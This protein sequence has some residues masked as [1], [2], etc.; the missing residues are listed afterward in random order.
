MPQSD[1]ERKRDERA[2]ARELAIPEP[3]DPD[4]RRQLEQDDAEWLQHY[5]PDVFYNPFTDDHLETIADVDRVLSYGVLKC[6][7]AERGDGKSS[8]VKYLMLK[9]ALQRQLW[10]P[11]V[12]C[13]T[14]PKASKTTRSIRRRLA[15]KAPTTAEI[16]AIGKRGGDTSGLTPNLLADDYPL[17][18]FTARYV[19]PWPS[20]SRNVTAN[21]GRTIHVEWGSAEGYFILP[22]WADECP[23][24]P[25]FMSL[26]WS[27]DE[28]QGCN[29]YDRRP[30][31]V[32]LDDL[33]SRDSLSSE[34]GVIADK[35][36]EQIETTVAG[37]GG[38]GRE[39]GQYFLCTIPSEVA[40]AA[41]YS[42]PEQKPAWDGVRK[43][44]I[45]KWPERMDLW[46]KYVSLYQKGIAEGDTFAREAHQ[47]YVDKREA[48]DAGSEVSNPYR[49]S[50]KELP[51]G[52]PKEISCLQ[53]CFNYIAKHGRES[54]NT[55]HQNDPPK[56]ENQLEVK[57]TPYHV[58]DCAGEMGQKMVDPSTEMICRGVDVRKI[59]LHHVVL[60]TEHALNHRIPDYGLQVHGNS[61]T[62][63]EQAEK[64][65]H[66]A[67]HRLA[68]SWDKD[69]L[70]DSN[71]M[72]RS[73]D[74][75]LID[76][77]WVGS[78]KTEDGVEKS[79]AS[80]PVEKFCMERGLRQWLP[81]K[82]QSPY[83][84]PQPGRGVIIGSNWHI[85]RGKGQKR[86]CDEV[87]W[88]ADH[89]HLLVEEL[90]MLPADNKDRF[91]LF[92]PTTDIYTNHK[93]FADHITVGATEL[94]N[95]LAKNVRSRK[96]RFARDHWWDSVAMAL[97]ARSIEH[98]M[99]EKASRKRTPRP[100]GE[101]GEDAR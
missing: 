99:R 94:K 33:D 2:R 81:A 84:A 43:R 45:K 55:E 98:A 46:D 26:G 7:A 69:P 53:R 88:N 79:W 5:L 96:P 32:M 58:S 92:A 87:I 66:E 71:G 30:D 28:L 56:R 41:K 24:G 25:I 9:K 83:K 36:E 100:L 80:Q 59:E 74:L 44:A 78:W 85:N 21:G 67:L 8:I 62:T 89:W 13:A 61:E 40:A 15:S 42:D 76:K 91:E 68:D 11:L 17:E 38:P 22:T 14:G 3:A 72:V 34:H 97:V 70:F 101:M 29:V 20:R 27:S 10:F 47:F 12:I 23:L 54:F 75:T 95:Q 39:L 48:M 4:R 49:Y 77:G 60:S 64:L 73:T 50:S 1:A 63:V 51:D 6:T 90:F 93:A 18:C 52:T 31:A 37:L 82:G 65:I 16:E 35:I 86:R 19:D 57:V